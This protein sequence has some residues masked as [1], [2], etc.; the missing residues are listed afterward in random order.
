MSIVQTISVT[1]VVPLQHHDP[2][3][4]THTRQVPFAGRVIA[5]NPETGKYIFEPESKGDML[6]T[7]LWK[8]RDANSRKTSA[9]AYSVFAA[10]AA[11][12]DAEAEEGAAPTA[13]ATFTDA[14]PAA[15]ASAAGGA[16]GALAAQ[17]GFAQGGVSGAVIDGVAGA[18]AAAQFG[19]T[20]GGV[21]GAVIGGVGGAGAAAQFVPGAGDQAGSGSEQESQSANGVATPGV[22][23]DDVATPGTLGGDCKTAPEIRYLPIADA[24]YVAD[25]RFGAKKGTRPTFDNGE[26]AWGPVPRKSYGVML[27]T[28]EEFFQTDLF[29]PADPRLWAVNV[30]GDPDMGTRVFDLNSDFE[31]DKDR[32]AVL[33]SVLRVVKKP[34]G[35]VD[36]H[37]QNTL[38]LQ[39]VDSGCKDVRGGLYADVGQGG[40]AITP[41]DAG[42]G[43]AI[44]E[45]GGAGLTF[46]TLSHADSG[47]NTAGSGKN[48]KHN[49]G[50]DEDGNPINAGHFNMGGYLWASNEEDGPFQYDGPFI[51]QRGP[52]P[53]RHVPGLF[54]TDVF[55]EFDA[56][57][58]HEFVGGPRS[59]KFKWRSTAQ[60]YY[61]EEKT[62]RTP[63]E[64]T[65][66]VPDEETPRTPF[67]DVQSVPAGKPRE[68]EF[69][70]EFERL[71]RFFPAERV[72]V[73]RDCLGAEPSLFKRR[74]ALTSLN[75]FASPSLLG[76]P[77]FLHSEVFC[78]FRGKTA[79]H[80]GIEESVAH[81]DAFTP[82]VG[83]LEWLGSQSDGGYNYTQEND[84]ESRYVG[85]TAPGSLWMLPPEVD[86][87]DDDT[88]FQPD[89]VTLSTVCLAVLRTNCYFASGVPRLEDG[90]CD[91]G[92]RWQADAVPDLVFERIDS[93]G[94][95]TRAV[96]FDST[97]G[98]GV[99]DAT[100]KFWG[101][102][103]AT[104]ALSDDRTYTLPDADG[105]LM[106]TADADGVMTE[107]SVPFVNSD[108]ILTEDNVNFF[109]DAG[110][111]RLG[112][113]TASPGAALDVRGTVVFNEDGGDNDFRVEGDT[114]V[115]L[116]LVDASTDRIG[117]GTTS[118]NV[119]LTIEDAGV[120]ITGVTAHLNLL[121]TTNAA[122]GGGTAML[123]S[124]S[125][126]INAAIEGLAT[127]SGQQGRM[128]LYVRPAA[129][130][131][132]E[133]T[134]LTATGLRI[135]PGGVGG[136]PTSPGHFI[137]G[138]ASGAN[139][140]AILQQDDI[141]DTFINFIGT[142]AADASRSISTLTT[143]GA[144]THH[145]RFEINGVQVWIAASTN[146]PT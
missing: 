98:L 30:A 117:I 123:F 68:A 2:L 41:A 100:F 57:I 101:T 77:Q 31:P 20:Q 58:G 105:T 120:A 111:A 141:D 144:T 138:N 35:S 10:V 116:F 86:M 7:V 112:I 18:G 9:W 126:N 60:L 8:R 5:R 17:F 14:S 44:T 142:S 22:L 89:D 132:E 118:P 63:F 4:G 32:G 72:I 137:Q 75:D 21:S 85:G 45:A 51:Y 23:G 76:R 42:P 113:G 136:D 95:A 81:H 71:R 67:E 1:G 13:G 108:G 83:R 114:E 16:A 70:E 104:G 125:N 56:T 59:G 84:E 39:F 37:G 90:G 11:A 93:S 62:P 121:D 25:D 33:H 73:D 130:N 66:S 26:A 139:P 69:L 6:G 54:F 49:I 24:D 119:K 110:N 43:Q 99:F 135:E 3:W 65:P 48:D 133:E 143:S 115:D 79:R 55:F 80:D 36:W 29:L 107:G 134:R 47:I 140:V 122:G 106:L 28:T 40:Q 46:G 129:G 19:S 52:K 27:T 38:A 128:S 103:V 94:V 53:F 78:D 34:S 74:T 127:G 146:D 82:I 92:Y 91:S 145:I 109:W 61:P 87:A 15:N 88:N 124:A 50:T 96:R 12:G 102:F 97:G 64:D 131:L